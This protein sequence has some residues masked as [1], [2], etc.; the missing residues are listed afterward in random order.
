[1][2][3]K[4]R[5]WDVDQVLLLPPSIQDLVPQGHMAHFVRDTV[6]DSL[7]L[8][9]IVNEYEEE[10]GYPPYDPVM[11]TALLLY[12]YSQGV[13]SGRGMAKACEERLDFMAVTALQ[14][15]DHRTINA[16]RNRHLAS[17]SGLFVQVLDLCRKAGLVKLGHV[18]IDGSKIR[19]NASKHKSMSYSRMEST[20]KELEAIV[21]GW[22]EQSDYEDALEDELYGEDKRGDELPSW[23]TDKK[24]RLRRVSEA[25]EEMKA[26]AKERD[27]EALEAQ[28][29]GKKKRGRPREHPLG[30]PR[31]KEQRNFTDP[32]SRIMKTK[33]GFQQCYNA[34][35]AVNAKH[36]VI[37]AHGLTQSAS[38][39]E[40]L[41]PL[42]DQVMETLGCYPNEISADAGY[43]S[44]SNLESIEKRRIRGYVATGKH[45]HGEPA[46]S[47]NRG[48]PLRKKMQER[49]QKGG[50]RSRY[51]YRKFTVEPVFGQIKEARRFF[52][53]LLRGM[54]KVPHEWGLVCIGHNLNKLA[55]ALA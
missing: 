7:D 22:L 14:K 27:Q 46:P 9:S 37:V 26:E 53:F 13:H 10:R 11:M 54:K 40:Q 2:A 42:L 36:Q 25:L 51:R 49:L 4:F 31:P 52:R 19:A 45:K 39:A 18:S 50:H 23:V 33:D 3:K 48:G 20:K 30:E 5:A 47:S 8:S 29:Q 43:C 12:G 38:D 21:Q 32:E 41:I 16:F 1:M 44:E 35:I 17:L 24:E 55:R 6:R 15:P 28:K 34:Q